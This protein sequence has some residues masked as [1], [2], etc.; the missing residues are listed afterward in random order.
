MKVSILMN[1][2]IIMLEVT[3]HRSTKEKKDKCYSCSM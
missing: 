1:N 3:F 2:K